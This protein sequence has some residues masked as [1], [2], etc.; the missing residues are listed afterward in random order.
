MSVH[1]A[2][3]LA[4]AV[5]GDAMDA[6]PGLS[7]GT[8]SGAIASASMSS[9]HLAIFSKRGVMG[10]PCARICASILAPRGTCGSAP[11]TPSADSAPGAGGAP[12]TAGTAGPPSGA[13]GTG[14]SERPA[15]A[16]SD[17]S[18]GKGG[19]SLD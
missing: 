7:I 18:G 10:R 6:S 14:G 11:G 4:L 3:E 8:P 17:D 19:G 15:C 13:S 9:I 16:C 5:N 1:G 12:G 2:T